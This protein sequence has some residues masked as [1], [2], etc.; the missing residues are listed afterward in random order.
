VYT[1]ATVEIMERIGVRELRNHVSRVVRRARGGERIVITVDG[2]PAAE[3]GPLSP[4]GSEATL[5]D[6]VAMGVAIAPRDPGPPGPPPEPIRLPDGVTSES[7][8]G[9][10]RDG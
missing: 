2:T 10:L 8:L 5:A 6:L 9:E 4:A 1:R 3:I 7:I